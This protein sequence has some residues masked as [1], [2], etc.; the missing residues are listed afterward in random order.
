LRVGFTTTL[1]EKLIAEIKIEAIKQ[2]KNVND[3]L[4][5]LIEK[6]LKERNKK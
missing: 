1:E 3:I 6:Y 5:E 2:G 4:E